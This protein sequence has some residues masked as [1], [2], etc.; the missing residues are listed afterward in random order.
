LTGVA[1]DSTSTRDTV[2]LTSTKMAGSLQWSIRNTS[3][4]LWKR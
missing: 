2:Q 1:K 4:R 3:S